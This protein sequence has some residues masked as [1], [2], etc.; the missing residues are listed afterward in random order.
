M[1]LTSNHFSALFD[2]LIHFRLKVNTLGYIVANDFFVLAT[3]TLFICIDDHD[4]SRKFRL[5]L[6]ILFTSMLFNG[7]GF[8]FSDYSRL[9]IL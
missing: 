7:N 1:L 3:G 9:N 8:Y 2:D 5:F 6:F 4:F